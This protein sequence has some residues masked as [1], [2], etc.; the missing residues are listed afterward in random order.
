VSLY[1]DI[2]ALL[3][4]RIT[5]SLYY[6]IPVLRCC[7]ISVLLHHCITVTVFLLCCMTVLVCCCITIWLYHCVPMPVLPCCC[8]TVLLYQYGHSTVI[9]HDCIS[10]STCCYIAGKYCSHRITEFQCCSI[11]A[12]LPYC[13]YHSIAVL[14]GHRTCRAHIL[15][16]DLTWSHT[17]R[18]LCVCLTWSPRPNRDLPRPNRDLESWGGGGG[19]TNMRGLLKYELEDCI[20]NLQSNGLRERG[21]KIG[22]WGLHRQPVI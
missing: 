21:S 2:T 22:A 20:A 19:L 7:Y 9:L 17:W 4:Y 11:T 12:L 8:I 13:M 5:V 6:C 10:V 16:A 1:Y 3:C 14:G 15:K 18:N